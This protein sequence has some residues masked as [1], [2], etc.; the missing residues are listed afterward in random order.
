MQQIVGEIILIAAEV[1]RTVGV[2]VEVCEFKF[3][4][5]STADMVAGVELI[6]WVV[7]GLII[8]VADEALALKFVFFAFFAFLN[9]S[10]RFKNSKVKT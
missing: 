8:N 4:L 1:G 5:R 2:P 9:S 7:G 3:V 6:R 10:M